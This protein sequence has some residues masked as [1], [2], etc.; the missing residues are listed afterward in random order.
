MLAQKN[1]GNHRAL[2][3]TS[4]IRGQAWL[5]H[6]NR[7][8][9]VGS[10]SGL[11]QGHESEVR[12]RTA[13]L[14]QDIES[15]QKKQARRESSGWIALSHYATECTLRAR[16]PLPPFSSFPGVALDRRCGTPLPLIH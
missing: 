10:S 3:V 4:V 13:N 15:V 1:I 6:G 7:E 9:P 2:D 16:A 11:S 5:A 12:Q 14:N 8:M